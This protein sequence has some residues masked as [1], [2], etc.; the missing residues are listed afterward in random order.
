MART[1]LG[2]LLGN[3]EDDPPPKTRKAPPAQP[4]VEAEPIR[5]AGQA[6]YLRFVRKETRLRDDQQNALTLH[7]RR[8]NRAKKPGSARI[9][10]NTL[11]R[12]AVDLLLARIDSA[13]G[14]DEDELLSSLE[15]HAADASGSVS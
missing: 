7:A 14:S 9:T 3:V 8:L 5:T 6:G 1:N 2:A 13:A 11:I 4:A 15:A 10:D 12:V